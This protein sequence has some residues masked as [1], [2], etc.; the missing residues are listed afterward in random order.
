MTTNDI[1]LVIAG[2]K[3]PNIDLDQF[4]LETEDFIVRL[5]EGKDIPSISIFKDKSIVDNLN[6]EELEVVLSRG[7]TFKKSEDFKK[8][9]GE[10]DNAGAIFVAIDKSSREYIGKNMIKTWVADDYTLP[11]LQQTKD[12]III[13][14]EDKIVHGAQ[15]IAEITSLKVKDG[16]KEEIGRALT[17]ACAKFI[18]TMNGQGYSADAGFMIWQGQFKPANNPDR[19]NFRDRILYGIL[20]NHPDSDFKAKLDESSKTSLNT[21]KD[22][23]PYLTPLINKGVVLSNEQLTGC[24]K[25]LGSD[26]KGGDPNKSN[27]AALEKGMSELLVKGIFNLGGIEHKLKMPFQ[28]EGVFN[29]TNGGGYITVNYQK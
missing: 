29:F 17:Y 26:Y 24:L 19:I 20:E 23:V 3:R 25:E 8:E 14:S 1:S 28:N 27:Q 11:K 18:E 9:D 13:T 10:K 12:G 15:N 4:S 6:R 7:Y 5:M 16:Y 22:I 2:E 21:K